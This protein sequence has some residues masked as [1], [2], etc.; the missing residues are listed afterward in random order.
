MTYCIYATCSHFHL[1]DANYE[2]NLSFYVHLKALINI[3]IIYFNKDFYP[4]CCAYFYMYLLNT[5]LALMFECLCRNKSIN[6]NCSPYHLRSWCF[7]WAWSRSFLRASHLEPRVPADFLQNRLPVL[8]PE[9]LVLCLSS[10]FLKKDPFC[11]VSAP[12]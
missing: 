3:T 10:P 9:F 12:F 4:R 2:P 5:D 11:V 6:L 8:G 7:P 1:I